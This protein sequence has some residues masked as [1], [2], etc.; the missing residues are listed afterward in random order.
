MR[1]QKLGD[2]QEG[3]ILPEDQKYVRVPSQFVGLP[4]YV[5]KCCVDGQLLDKHKL[6]ECQQ[7]MQS[8]GWL[9]VDSIKTDS[10]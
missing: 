9:E 8:C 2:V 7:K 5:G 4:Q 6:S 3:G 1:P 10:S